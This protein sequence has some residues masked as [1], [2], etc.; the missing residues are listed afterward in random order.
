MS[1]YARPLREDDDFDDAYDHEFDGGF[2]AIGNSPFLDALV[3]YMAVVGKIISAE[4][5]VVG[6]PVAMDAFQP[7]DA[8]RA[9]R[10]IGYVTKLGRAKRI[11]QLTFP[12]CLKL[13]NGEFVT[14]FAR[15]GN[16]L[17]II[18]PDVEGGFREAAYTQLN[19]RFSGD[20]I[21]VSPSVEALEN[22]HVGQIR[23]GHWFWKHI[24]GQKWLSLEVF[25]ATLIANCLAVAVSLFALQVYDRVIPNAS[26][27]TL[28]VLGTGALVAIVFEMI[29]KIVR[30]RLID[31]M[32]RQVET[33]LSAELVTKLQN[34]R[35]NDRALGPAALGA[36][37]REF[38]AI[39]EFFTATAMGSIA[40]I[41]FV[42]IFLVLIY[43]IAGPVVLVPMAAVALI[44]VTSL[45]TRR[46]LTRISKDMQ[47]ANAAQARLLNEITYGAEAIKLSRAENKF[48]AAW[49]DL[50]L[51][52]SSKTQ[53]QR[54]TAARLSFMSQAIQQM[55]YVTAVIAGVY[56]VFAGAFSIGAIIAISILSTRAIAP[57]TQL[58]GALARW[59][60]VRV[61]LEGLSQIAGSVQERDHN[62]KYSRRENL[63][64]RIDIRDLLFRYAEDQDIALKIEKLG[65]QPG[66]KI[67]ILGR[68]GSGKSTLL[69]ILSGLYD[70]EQGEVRI[71]GLDIRQ[72]DPVDLRRN[73]GVLT[74]DVTLF[75]GTLLDNLKLGPRPIHEGE[76]EAALKFSGLWKMVER[77]PLG[78]DMPV[79]DGGMGLSVG[80]RQSLGLARMYLADPQI[81]LLDEPTA[82]MDQTLEA[83]VIERLREWL[84]LKT[85]IL[86][87]H[88]TEI[89]SICDRIAVMQDGK[90]ALVGP[91]DE[92]LK[93][94]TN[95]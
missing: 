78:L 34:M 53:D 74:Q 49:E 22:K 1:G 81:V 18:D 17:K 27:Q 9:L 71:D 12:V 94:L 55:A 47:G 43:S 4:E 16:S 70:F 46:A 73:M 20:Y 2:D 89:I 91:S 48:Q 40:D 84:E 25:V 54:A 77:H 87:T 6:L 15:E 32:G 72:I 63:S 93:K 83:E 85:C 82:A 61:A 33:R 7:E 36:M 64:G 11:D 76:L 56:M 28:W 35:M 69:K 51:L 31:D 13:K 37:M 75:S 44:V 90:I 45:L 41:P 79:A 95:K 8:P 88:R 38:S 19:D 67:A 42:I 66:E 39:R 10:R 29:L 21:Q 58:S 92:I 57:V 24:T 65:I 59:Q 26:T 60:Q 68:N 5:L 14:V 86:T 62:R 30:G 80:Q 23:D 3:A 50:S 52:I